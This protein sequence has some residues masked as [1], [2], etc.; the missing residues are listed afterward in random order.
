MKTEKEAEPL[1]FSLD[2]IR[3]SKNTPSRNPT[4]THLETGFW[5][6]RSNNKTQPPSGHVSNQR[7]QNGQRAVWAIRMA[8]LSAF[9][10]MFVSK[11]VS[12]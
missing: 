11:W 10:L 7:Y 8:N 2:P 4:N 6:Y 3:F 1:Y 9:I 12:E 5:I